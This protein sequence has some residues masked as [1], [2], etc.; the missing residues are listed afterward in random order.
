VGVAGFVEWGFFLMGFAW[1]LTFVGIG[2]VPN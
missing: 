1:L 2:A